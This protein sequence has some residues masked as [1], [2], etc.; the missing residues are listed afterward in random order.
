MPTFSADETTTL[1]TL[2]EKVKDLAVDTYK[3]GHHLNACGLYDPAK[4]QLLMTA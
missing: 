4:K 1:E 3:K 2:M